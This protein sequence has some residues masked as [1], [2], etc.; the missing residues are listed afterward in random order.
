MPII[1]EPEPSAVTRASSL[2]LDLDPPDV[3]AATSGRRRPARRAAA[4]TRSSPSAT[5][6]PL[7][8]LAPARELADLL[9]LLVVGAGDHHGRNEKGAVLQEAAPGEAGVGGR[10]GGRAADASR[11]ASAN[12]RNVSASR[13]AMSAR[14]LRSSSTPASLRP[15][16]KVRVRH[17][18]EAGRG[19]DAGDP[20]PAEVALAVAPVAVARR[21]PPSSALPWPACSSS[22]ASPR[23]PFV[24]SSVARRFLRGVDGAL[25]AGHLPLPAAS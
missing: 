24:R 10:L 3:P 8:A 11:A 21:S 2:G 9:E 1:R 25:D 19:V 14:T 6:R 4:A 7:V 17:A 16:M 13:T 5:K 23:K 20:Q 18:V 15:C 22:C 12:R